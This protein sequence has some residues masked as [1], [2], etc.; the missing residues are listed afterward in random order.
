MLAFLKALWPFT[1]AA[2]TDV[3]AEVAKVQ[4]KAAADVAA[5][6]KSAVV[7]ATVAAVKAK[8]AA[9]DTIVADYKANLA[10]QLAAAKAAPAGATGAT[11]ATGSASGTT[12]G[13]SSKA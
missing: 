9:F 10:A 1:T 2:A 3:E 4:A 6:R 5:L 13:P 11:G 7:T 12:D 8:A